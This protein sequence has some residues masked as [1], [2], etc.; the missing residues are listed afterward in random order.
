MVQEQ[1]YR[2]GTRGTR[3]TALLIA[4]FAFAGLAAGGAPPLGAAEIFDGMAGQWIGKGTGRRNAGDPAEKIYC[5]I[6][7]TPRDGGA[8]MKQ[9][10]RCALGNSSGTIDGHIEASGDGRFDGSL[11][12]PAY[13]GPAAISGTGTARRMELATRYEDANTGRAISATIVFR[14]V[15]DG[16]YRMTTMATDADSGRTYEASDIL[17]QRR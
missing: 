4:A 7:N 11:A 6:T 13:K 14:L 12:S 10:G 2:Q 15:S 17:F 9:S 5:R 8:V 3:G 1:A 16:K